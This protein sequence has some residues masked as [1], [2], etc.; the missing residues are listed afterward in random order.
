MPERH[1]GIVNLIAGN[2]IPLSLIVLLVADAR[3]IYIA[4]AY[5]MKK[6]S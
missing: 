1:A 5:I 2:L 3:L 6:R 4:L